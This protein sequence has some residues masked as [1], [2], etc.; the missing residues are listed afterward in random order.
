VTGDDALERAVG[1]WLLRKESEPDLL[2]GRFAATLPASLRDGF[3]RELEELAAID[4]LATLAPPRDL[5]RRLGDFRV[6][7][8]LGRGA[9]GV[10][11]DAEQV[12]TGRRV[13]LKVL[14]SH[15]A[16]DQA[17][18]SRFEREARTAAALSH[19]GIVT[20]L[21]FGRTSE[22]SWLAMERLEGR[23]LQRLCWAVADARDVDHDRAVAV[24]RDPRRLA[25]ALAEA[26]RALA[27]AHDHGVVHRDVKP[28]NLLLCDDGRL[29][30]LDFGLATARE[31]EPLTLTRAGDLLGTPL[32]MAPE[33]AVGA[34]NGTPRSDV[35][36]LGAVLYECL[37]GQ[38][39]VAPGP[40]ATVIDAILNRDPLPPRRVR[41][42]VPEE[43][44]RIAMQCLDKSPPRRYPSAAALADD[45]QRFV[46]GHMVRAR[47]SGVLRRSLR[48]LRR[49]P[50]LAA[51]F[52]L[53]A[54]LLVTSLFAWR[55]AVHRGERAGVLQEV[56]DVGRIEALLGT[57][58]ER[59]TAFGGASLRYYA[60]RGLG[61]IGGPVGGARSVQAEEALRLAEDLARRHPEDVA[62]LRLRAVAW[63]DVGDDDAAVDRAVQALLQHPDAASQDFMLG[64]VRAGQRGDVET[65]ARLRARAT[66]D[67]AATA[68]WTGLWHQDEQD[69]GAAIRALTQAIDRA[70]GPDGLTEEMRYQA[71]LHRGWCRTCP[72]IVDFARAKEDLL[73]ASALRPGYPTPKLLWAA[74][75]CL[76]AR[77]VAD[78]AEPVAAVERALAGAEPWVVVLTAR[79]LVSLA[80]GGIVQGG[81]V[82][83]G[84]ELSPIAMVAI[85]A[86]VAR[87]LAATAL[88]LLDGL[89]PAARSFEVSLHRTAALA[90]LGRH[91]EALRILHELREAQPRTR[92]AMLDLQQARIEAA[93][94]RTRAALASSERASTAEPR[95]V[96]AWRLRAE[97][98][99]RVGDGLE[100]LRALEGAVAAAAPTTSA[101][102]A[103]FADAV[104]ELPELQLA[105][106]EL[107]LELGRT[108]DAVALA[109]EGP[110]G[111]RL[112]GEFSPRFQVRRSLLL[113]RLGG[114][115]VVAA[116]AG[117][118][119]R[120]PRTVLLAAGGPQDLAAVS[121]A[122]LRAAVVRGWLPNERDAA[123]AARLEW[124]GDAVGARQEFDAGAVEAAP[125]G[126]L[127][128]NA[129]ALAGA[130]DLAAAVLARTARLLADDPAHDEARL[131][132]AL[133]HHLRG[134]TADALA[135]LAPQAD[136]LGGDL[137]TRFLLAVLA[138]A[139][140]DRGIVRRALTRDGTMLRRADLDAARAALPVALPESGEELLESAR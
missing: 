83:F 40:L 106:A 84:A 37:C 101:P 48:G 128:A 122:A 51:A 76:E 66:G 80:E 30:V 31:A 105:R 47:A 44:A 114:A 99:R 135:T 127:L 54:V 113:S 34:E 62:L 50:A 78:L 97:L 136:G 15:V 26:A 38:P 72:E 123:V 100:R 49:R 18:V 110:F 129:A 126:V 42:D 117:A 8:E 77:G 75:R 98:C 14:H 55:I 96:A 103:V 119:S 138:R 6:L 73:Q 71:L 95:L 4:G 36:A 32:Y 81:P 61:E 39:P 139:S 90:M 109:R 91:D 124:V 120:S 134:D 57:A 133:L 27:F 63:L 53:V 9:M 116:D 13:A 131:L 19:P 140:G 85:P 25:Q 23:S 108:A 132:Q 41:P 33:Q 93:L 79:V 92:A 52:T 94:G 69:H 104:A 60:R 17:A 7:G 10:V 56:V 137:R 70:R 74:L 89:A 82:Q 45:L 107:L 3:L 67:D 88:A 125:L 65:A 64:A 29:V 22:A 121:D 28:A 43:L 21:E 59:I 87:A 11:Y 12:S 24:L 86:E 68:F 112:A 111:G 115:G 46:D 1:E 130:P 35:Y 118:E 20:V 102:V 5:P 2:P 58:P 16:S